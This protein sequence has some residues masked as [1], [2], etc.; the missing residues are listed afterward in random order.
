M[1]EIESVSKKTINNGAER[2]IKLKKRRKEE[3]EKLI[4]NYDYISW[5]EKFTTLY[6]K[7]SD[8]SWLYKSEELSEEDNANVNI[9]WLFFEAISDYCNKYYIDISSDRGDEEECVNIRHNGIGY[10]FGLVCGQ[11]S[12]VYVKRKIPEENAI[13]FDDI[14][15]D[16]VPM[17]FEDKKELLKKFEQTLAEMK[18]IG[19]PMFNIL[20]IVNK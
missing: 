11:G 2:L 14:L 20:E 3:K 5:L 1:K 18:K 7:F 17:D 6:E 12:Y 15:N 9:L 13:A 16:S 8:D 10:Q 19:I 4:S